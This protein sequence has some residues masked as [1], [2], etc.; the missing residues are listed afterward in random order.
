MNRKLANAIAY[1][2]AVESL[3]ILKGAVMTRRNVSINGTFLKTCRDRIYA[4]VQR[5]ERD[6]LSEQFEDVYIPLFDSLSLITYALIQ[7]PIS[8]EY[9]YRANEILEGLKRK[10]WQENHDLSDSEGGAA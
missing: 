6:N 9:I 7:T 10:T 3:P 1:I 8:V 4:V 5:F 2:A